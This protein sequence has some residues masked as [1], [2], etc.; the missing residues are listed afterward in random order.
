MLGW[1]ATLGRCFL[2]HPLLL[3]HM[4]LF[5]F[6]P[7][8]FWTHGLGSA[9]LLVVILLSL[10]RWCYPVEFWVEKEL[11]T[12]AS[13]LTTIWLRVG[14]NKVQKI[15]HDALLCVVGGPLDKWGCNLC[16]N[17]YTHAT[18]YTRTKWI[19]LPYTCTRTLCSVIL[20]ISTHIPHTH[21]Q[22]LILHRVS[23]G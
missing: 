11:G 19:S 14:V 23:L 10:F 1:R 17:V 15:S 13:W 18:Y 9:Y 16:M 20:P 21:T 3:D 12:V 6:L 8:P 5:S 4:Y 7:V 22:S 2:S